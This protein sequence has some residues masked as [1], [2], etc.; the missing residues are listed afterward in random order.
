[1]PA[2][3]AILVLATACFDFGFGDGVLL[4][5]GRFLGLYDIAL[6]SLNVSS[7]RDGGL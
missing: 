7:G 6:L 1:L 5:I 2:R 3:G 4:G